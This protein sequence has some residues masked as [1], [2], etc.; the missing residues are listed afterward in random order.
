MTLFAAS[1]S[2]NIEANVAPWV[3]V[4]MDYC[5]IHSVFIY[6]SVVKIN[7]EILISA[8]ESICQGIYRGKFA[9]NSC[10]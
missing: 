5:N 9:Y 6:D 10:I 8:V 2:D 1:Q 7:T 4:K 3:I